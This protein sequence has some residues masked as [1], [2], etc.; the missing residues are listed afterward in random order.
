MVDTIDYAVTQNIDMKHMYIIQNYRV[1]QKSSTEEISITFEQV[2]SQRCV[3]S[4]IVGI[5]T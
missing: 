4:Q 1:Y 3:R 2:A 5:F